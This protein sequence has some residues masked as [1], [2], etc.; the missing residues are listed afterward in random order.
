MTDQYSLCLS[1]YMTQLRTLSATYFPAI[2]GKVAGWQVS[3]DDTVVREGGDYFVIL[4]PGTFDM[5]QLSSSLQN[6]VWRVRTLL[7]MRYTEYANIWTQYRAFRSAILG[8]RETSPLTAYGIQKQEF[9]ASDE[10]G[11]LRDDSGNY[12][13]FVQQTLECTITQRVL[14]PRAF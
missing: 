13:G 8:L 3:E 10:A 1:A 6:N 2:T 5:P 9:S 7:F 14:V 12:V 4:R 11:Y